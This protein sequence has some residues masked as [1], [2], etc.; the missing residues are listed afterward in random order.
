MCKV[1]A[2]IN[3]LVRL[4]A[5]SL[6]LSGAL[7][8]ALGAS[9]IEGRRLPRF[10]GRI[11]NGL[12]I[13][14]DESTSRIAA[15]IGPPQSLYELSFRVAV[16]F[17]TG[18]LIYMLV[19]ETRMMIMQPRRPA[20]PLFVNKLCALA[21]A[22][23][24]LFL[25]LPYL[26]SPPM[27]KASSAPTMAAGPASLKKGMPEGNAS[28][29][30]QSA[31]LCKACHGTTSKAPRSVGPNLWG[32]VGRPIASAAGYSYSPALRAVGGEWTR[33]TLDVFLSDPQAFAPGTA[34][35]ISIEDDQERANVIAF[36]ETLK[37]GGD[38]AKR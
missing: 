10:L 18:V 9:G 5:L 13:A 28:A 33:E 1:V 30:A 20:S 23:G 14:L 25:S 22:F 37:D 26:A 6:L 34:M 16:A 11:A 27:R 31:M 35:T 24:I 2:F 19:T 32:V 4:A 17:S 36:L 15:A 29:G 21:L 8:A 12:G 7:L 3:A 38:V